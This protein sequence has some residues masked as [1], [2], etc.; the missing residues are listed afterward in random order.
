M[1]GVSG[2]TEVSSKVSISGD[3]SSTASGALKILVLES[4]VRRVSRDINPVK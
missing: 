4:E 1:S 2:S 3:I